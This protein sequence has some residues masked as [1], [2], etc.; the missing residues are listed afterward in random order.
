MSELFPQHRSPHRMSDYNRS[1]SSYLHSSG[2]P[3]RWRLGGCRLGAGD[4]GDVEKP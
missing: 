1:E 4:G 3:V 2:V